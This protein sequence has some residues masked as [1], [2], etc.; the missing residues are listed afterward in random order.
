MKEA[1]WVLGGLFIGSGILMMLGP[2]NGQGGVGVAGSDGAFSGHAAQV[3]STTGYDTVA[4]VMIFGQGW[5]AII[6]GAIG[7][8]MLVYANANA[9]KDTGGY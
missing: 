4:D 8:S 5:L 9:W 1:I 7:L 2:F 3:Y 6:L